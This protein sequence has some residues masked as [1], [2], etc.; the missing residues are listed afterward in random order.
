MAD[1]TLNSLVINSSGRV[2]FSGLGSKIDFQATVDALIAAKRI[3]VDRL[4]AQIEKSQQKIAA[5]QD[6]RGKL[7]TLQ[8]S[9]KNLYGAVTVDASRNI[10]EAKQAFAS[11]SRSDG[12]A[13]SNPANLLGVTVTNRAA[14]GKHTIEVV[15]TA[16]SHRVG[17]GTFASATQDLGTARGLGAN[18]VSG[19]IQ[20]GGASI[21]VRSS[22]TLQS[23]VDRINN[24]NKGAGATGVSASIVRVSETESYMALTVDKA[25]RSLGTDI[26]LGDPDGVLEQLGVLSG[27][28]IDN[29]FQAARKA[30]FYADGILDPVTKQPLLI[31]RDSNTISDLFSGVTLSLYQAEPGTTITIDVDRNLSQAKAAITNFVDAYNSV[32]GFLNQQLDTDA[33]TGKPR[34]D[35]TLFGSTTLSDIETRL[36][37][38]VGG[39]GQGTN[40]AFSVLAQIGIGFV[41]NNALADPLA[42]NTLTIDNE[43]LDQ[44][45]IANIDDVK[46]LFGFDFNASTPQVSMLAF[47][48]STSYKADGYKLDVTWDDVAGKIASA[49]VDGQPASVNGRT[50]KVESGGAKGLSLFFNGGADMTGIDLN[51]SVGFGSQMFFELGNLL[52]SQ[53][54]L[55][56]TEIKALTTGN[57]QKQTRIEEMTVRLDLQRETLLAKYIKMETALTSMNQ[58]IENLKQ[59]TE[60]MFSKN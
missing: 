5:Y 32:R 52:D 12:Q 28:A 43:K 25:G 20:I 50:I 3:P 31:Q 26:A 51:F 16:A 47:N 14:V 1:T 2:S 39:G 6:F 21:E 15:Q 8:D 29:E 9:L 45:L 10:F 48:G 41:N 55:V 18:S 4:E 59:M 44:A 56:E 57:Q 37:R 13:A 27:G 35:A 42:V 23:L 53:S 22:D 34:S 30:Q 58:T 33:T 19:N 7:S 11:A 40:P 17:S 24:A 46:K 36:S 60:S 54:G 38:I 49:T